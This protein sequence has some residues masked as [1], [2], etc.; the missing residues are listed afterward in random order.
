MP[1]LLALSLQQSSYRRTCATAVLGQVK[2]AVLTFHPINCLFLLFEAVSTT[3]GERTFQPHSHARH[4]QVSSTGTW[5]FLW[6]SSGS[7]SGVH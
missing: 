3:Q 5:R 4:M 7:C 2:S 6:T 1:R